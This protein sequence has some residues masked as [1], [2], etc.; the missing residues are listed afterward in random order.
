[1]KIEEIP[2]GLRNEYI[3]ICTCCGLSQKILTQRDNLPEYET[4]IYLQCQC[5]EYI[6]F[7]LPVN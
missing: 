1:M 7:I 4:E 6:Q 5:G 3:S 2:L